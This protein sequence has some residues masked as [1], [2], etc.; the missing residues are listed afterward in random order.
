M[1][2]WFTKEENIPFSQNGDSSAK[3]ME[4]IEKMSNGDELIFTKGSYLFND[5]VILKDRKGI[6]L[7]GYGATVIVNYDLCH[8][9]DCKNAFEFIHCDD[10]D[11]T[12]FTFTTNNPTNIMGRI[13]S[14]NKEEGYFDVILPHNVQVAG[15]EWIEGLDTCNEDYS[16]NFHIGWADMGKPHRYHKINRNTLR[17]P[18]WPSKRPQLD[19]VQIGELICMRY[20]LYAPGTFSF[21][22]C[23]NVLLEDITIEACP[24]I[25]CCAH[26]RSSNFTFRRYNIKLAKDS[27]QGIACNTDGIHF[28]GLCG[29][30]VMEDCHFEYMG[31]DSLNMHSTCGTVYAIHDNVIDSGVLKMGHTIDE[32]PAE[33]LSTAF[34]RK[35]DILYIYDPQTTR[36]K[37]EVT[38]SSYTQ[39]RFEFSKLS[40]TMEVG[41]II[42]NSA[43]YAETVIKN[44]SVSRSRARGFLVKTH[45]V[46][47]D[48]CYFEKTS[49]PAIIASC[50]ISLWNEMGPVHHMVISN[51]C[52]EGC[53]T[54]MFRSRAD[55]IIIG[56]GPGGPRNYRTDDIGV[57]ADIKLINNKFYNMPD[58]AIFASGVDGLEIWGNQIYNCCNVPNDLPDEKFSYD[59]IIVNSDNVSYVDNVS[60]TNKNEIYKG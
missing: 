39:N 56:G 24:G 11:I 28:T 16:L 20:S 32:P 53:N 46:L 3:L 51:C 36:K 35:G 5:K 1:K 30:L 52:I 49:G 31:D 40:G 25:S 37:A 43:F 50:G 59:T 23:N 14:K 18:V 26:A 60:L 21:I 2:T 12:G 47:I 42:V 29:K 6:K 4:L 7:R 55:G 13:I 48:G 19:N 45:N 54:S 44:C 33:N 58:S 22:G 15:N 57:Y 17:F 41:D 27:V 38:V 34:A 9:N 8:P 10:I